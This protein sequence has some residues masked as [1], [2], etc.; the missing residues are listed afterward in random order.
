MSIILHHIYHHYLKYNIYF[1]LDLLLITM[2]KNFFVLKIISSQGKVLVSYY[3][4][5]LW[6]KMQT[7]M[8]NFEKLKCYHL[9]TILHEGN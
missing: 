7:S 8:N 9:P 3:K 1:K 2:N 4:I 6:E 5:V